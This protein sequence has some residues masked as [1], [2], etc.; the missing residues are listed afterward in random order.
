MAACASALKKSPG[1]DALVF[2]LQRSSLHSSLWVILLS[3]AAS[4]ALRDLNG[5][6]PAP[7]LLHSV[8]STYANRHWRSHQATN[9]LDRTR[10]YQPPQA[11]RRGLSMLL[12]LVSNPGLKPGDK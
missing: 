1:N 3:A 2:L 10:A 12:R 4:T 5:Q 7:G 8:I 6:Y 11:R 9:S